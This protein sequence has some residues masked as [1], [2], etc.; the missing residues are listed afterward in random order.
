MCRLSLPAAAGGV[1]PTGIVVSTE[2]TSSAAEFDIGATYD[3]AGVTKRRRVARSFTQRTAVCRPDVS[4]CDT[5]SAARLSRFHRGGGD[6]QPSRLSER[7][8]SLRCT[9]HNTA[10]SDNMR[11]LPLDISVS[12]QSSVG[13][14]M[15]GWAFLFA[16]RDGSGR[17]IRCHDHIR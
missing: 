1:T 3:M 11:H 4:C 9:I 13:P 16:G 15:V 12:S 2:H 5:K 14:T 7:S 10:L 8:V 6:R 17:Q